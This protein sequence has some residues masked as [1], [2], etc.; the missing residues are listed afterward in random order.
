[1][2]F[3]P[4]QKVVCI[5]AD[6]RRDRQP[7]KVNPRIAGLDGLTLRAVYTIRSMVLQRGVMLV[8]LVEI[9]RPLWPGW[10]AEGEPGFA[11]WR[12]RPVRETS[13]ECLRAHLAP[14]KQR[15][16]A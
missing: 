2:S 4:G 10:E 8:R 5:D 11:P 7:W 16:R 14:I 12:F 9:T 13:I 15:E 3:H 1:M 6:L